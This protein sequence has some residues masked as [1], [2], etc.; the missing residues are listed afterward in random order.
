M[1]LFLSEVLVAAEQFR[2]DNEITA[3]KL[4]ARS[5]TYFLDDDFLSVIDDNGE[6]T[7]YNAERDTF[8]LINPSLRIQTQLSAYETKREIDAILEKIRIARLRVMQPSTH[9]DFAAKPDFKIETDK[10]S[11]QI[12]LQSNWVDYKLTTEIFNDNNIAKRYFD[13]C[14]LTC[15][16]NFRITRWYGQL[17]RLEVNRILRNQNRFPQN[18]TVTFYPDGKKSS[19]AEETFSSSHKLIRRL[20]DEDKNKINSI[21]NT[22]NTFKTVTPEE[23]QQTINGATVKQKDNAHEESK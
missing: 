8:T 21:R 6:I 18:I 10:K 11:G 14:N 13:F 7:Y 16:L 15:Y 3:G 2:I 12:A 5:K 1:V 4:V 19:K 9:S 20:T 22:M 23:Y 17:Y